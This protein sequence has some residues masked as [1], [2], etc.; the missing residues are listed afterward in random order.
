[1][2]EM[3]R[4]QCLYARRE[5]RSAGFH[6]A[7]SPIEG[8]KLLV[9]VDHSDIDELAMQFSRPILGGIHEPSAETGIPHTLGPVL[10]AVIDAQD[11]KGLSPDA[12][13]RDVGQGR[14]HNLAGAVLAAGSAS[15]RRLFQRAYGVV[16]LP[17]GG[18]PVMRVVLLEVIANALQIRCG[19]G[20]PADT[21]V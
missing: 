19:G 16:N 10:C 9:Q 2:E 14:E 7:Q 12:V 21:H 13:N 1:M 17:Q 5:F 3:T 4:Q 6:I 8:G 11:F 18:L 20:R 15:V